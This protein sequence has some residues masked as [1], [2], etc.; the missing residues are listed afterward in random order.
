M[1]KH[2][3]YVLAGLFCLAASTL[4]NAQDRF[5]DLDLKDVLELEITSVSKKP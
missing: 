1:C 2:N 4:A 3:Y 5:L